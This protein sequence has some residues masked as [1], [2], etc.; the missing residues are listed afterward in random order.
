MANE[1]KRI[2]VG[3]RNQRKEEKWQ[4]TGSLHECHLIRRG[5]YGRHQ[6]RGTD[7]LDQAA[8]R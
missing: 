2:G 8:E 5:C 1:I 4:R 7:R 6:P 3:A